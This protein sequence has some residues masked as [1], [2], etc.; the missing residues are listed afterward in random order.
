MRAHYNK[1]CKTLSR[2][3]KEA[4]RQHY[5]RLIEKAGN[6]IK[7]TWNIIKHETGKLQQMEQIPPDLIK[8]EKFNDP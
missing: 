7:T 8:N 1:Y 3:I 2:V 5:Y 4:K 6:K